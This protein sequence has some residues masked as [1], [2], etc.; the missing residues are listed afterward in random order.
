MTVQMKTS[1]KCKLIYL[2]RQALQI[3]QKMSGQVDLENISLILPQEISL[4]LHAIE[5]HTATIDLALLNKGWREKN[6]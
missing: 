5:F 3:I 6:I 1:H 4:K 2:T